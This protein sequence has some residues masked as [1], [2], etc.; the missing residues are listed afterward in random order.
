MYTQT[1][2]GFEPGIKASKAFVLNHYTIES[3]PKLGFE[4]RSFPLHEKIFPIK[5]PQATHPSHTKHR[6]FLYISLLN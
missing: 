1:P 4:P 3:L 5:L 6:I 2:P